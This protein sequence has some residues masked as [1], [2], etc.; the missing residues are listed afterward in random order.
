MN[1]ECILEEIDDVIEEIYNSG[2]DYEIYDIEDEKMDVDMLSIE[3]IKIVVPELNVS[4]RQAS[5]CV[6]DEDQDYFVPDFNVTLIYEQDENTLSD[7]IFSSP[8]DICVALYNYF[9]KKHY[10]I[11]DIGNMMCSIDIEEA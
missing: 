1:R 2:I 6:Y 8:D 7:Y 11:D 5:V 3:G 10:S 9:Y 4:I